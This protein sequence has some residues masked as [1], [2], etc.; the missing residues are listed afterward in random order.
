[1]NT[2]GK[3]KHE[4]SRVKVIGGVICKSCTHCNQY[5]PQNSDNFYHNGERWVAQC[6]DCH[7]RMSQESYANNDVCGCK[8]CTQPRARSKSGRIYT[9]CREHYNEY[10]RRYRKEKNNESQ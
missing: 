10:A 9:Y 3:R 2:N 7:N 5:F 4:Y 1:M 6:W 8:D